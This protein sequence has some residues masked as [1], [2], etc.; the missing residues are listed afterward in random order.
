VRRS[1]FERAVRDEFG[2]QAGSLIVD[3][4]LSQIGDRTAAEALDAGVA[5]REVWLALCA[6]TDVPAERRYGVGRLEPKS[7]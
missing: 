3:L 1:E 7:R 5:P 6:E 2:P 4:A